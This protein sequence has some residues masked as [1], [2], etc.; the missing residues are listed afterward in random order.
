MSINKLT[1]CLLGGV[2]NA[3]PYQNPNCIAKH[4][5]HKT[6]FLLSCPEFLASVAK[7]LGPSTH[8]LFAF[9]LFLGRFAKDMIF[10]DCPT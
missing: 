8:F 7:D 5:G 4:F 1:Q 3:T 2:L 6:H 10:N 9:S